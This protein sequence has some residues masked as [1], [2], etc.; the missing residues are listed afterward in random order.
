MQ[1]IHKRLPRERTNGNNNKNMKKKVI[2]TTVLCLTDIKWL[3]HQHCHYR[4]QQY[5]ERR[6]ER[7]RF[8]LHRPAV[9]KDCRGGRTSLRVCQLQIHGERSTLGKPKQDLEQPV[10]FLSI[11]TEIGKA[12]LSLSY[13]S[14]TQRPSYDDLDGTVS[15]VNRLTLEGGNPYLSPMKIHTVEL[16]GAWKQ[17]F[18]KV[19][20]EHRRMPS[21]RQ[22]N[23]MARM[24]K[25]SCSPWRTP[26]RLMSCK[27]L[28]AHNSRSAFGNP[29]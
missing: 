8:S 6:E 3:Q 19:S 2:T 15:Y 11:S 9:R 1:G 10:P 7:G 20:S 22:R 13:T 16:M 14:K 23:L 29:K 25:W 17:F 21:Y 24:E 27:H 12:Q 26:K 5:Q 4:Q 18:A 28:L